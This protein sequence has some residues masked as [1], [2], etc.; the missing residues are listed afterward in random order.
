M[1]NTIQWVSSTELSLYL[2][3]CLEIQP[4]LK[5]AVSYVYDRFH[6]SCR[7]VIFQSQFCELD[8]GFIDRLYILDRLTL[9]YSS[10]NKTK[11]SLLHGG[12]RI[13]R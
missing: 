12:S 5:F 13:K 3:V 9:T 7:N 1:K 8:N 2:H 6:S 10:L 11:N 4:L